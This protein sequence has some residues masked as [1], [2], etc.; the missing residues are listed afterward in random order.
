MMDILKVVLEKAKIVWFLLL[1]YMCVIWAWLSKLISIRLQKMK[2]V[3]TERKMEKLFTELGRCVFQLY[4]EGQQ[5]LLE[6]TS[7]QEILSEIQQQLGKKNMLDEKLREIEE[8]YRA[9]LEK[10]REKYEK[11]RS[12]ISSSEPVTEEAVQEA[13]PSEAKEE[14]TSK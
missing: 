7:V 1:R 13:Q 9:K 14:T 6:S 12:G 4:Q 5:N 11:R 2:Q 3:G 8:S 10:A